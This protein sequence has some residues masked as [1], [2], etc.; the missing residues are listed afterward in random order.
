MADELAP[1]APAPASSDGPGGPEV[2]DAFEGA[3]VTREVDLAA[4]ADD[5]WSAVTDPELRSTWLDDDDAV[6]RTVRVDES[7]P[8]R[9]LVWTWWQDPGRGGDDVG[10]STVEIALRP[11]DGGGTRVV[12]TE[13]LVLAVPRPTARAGAT[14]EASAGVTSA[15]ASRAWDRRL[16]GLE[17]MFTGVLASVR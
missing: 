5:V 1:A 15:R 8:G 16:L 11:L 14:A 4:G 10:P 2:P 7:D 3:V 17:L 13:T 12:V 6:A 9:R